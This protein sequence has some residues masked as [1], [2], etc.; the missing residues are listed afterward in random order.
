[1]PRL[2]MMAGIIC[3]PQGMRKDA[4]PLMYEHPNSTKYCRKIPHVMDHCCIETRRPRMAGAVISD[5]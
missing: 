5:W 1:M 4:V 2:S 3:R